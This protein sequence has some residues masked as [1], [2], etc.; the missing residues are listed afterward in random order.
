MSPRDDYPRIQSNYTERPSPARARSFLGT[1]PP[2]GPTTYPA[3]LPASQNKSRS[4]IRDDGE[5]QS[6]L[7]TLTEEN[8]A[9]ASQNP[10]LPSTSAAGDPRDTRRQQA[11]PGQG[12]LPPT[13]QVRVEQ[14]QPA[15]DGQIQPPAPTEQEVPPDQP[16]QQ[17][18]QQGQ[19]Q[20]V[21]PNPQAVAQP[22]DD[23]QPAKLDSPRRLGKLSRCGTA[24][25]P[26]VSTTTVRGMVVD[27]VAI[28]GRL[29]Q[30][31]KE[32]T[33]SAYAA[34]G[35]SFRRY[36]QRSGIDEGET[37]HGCRAGC[38]IALHM[39]GASQQEVMEHLG[40]F[41]KQ[42]AAHYM[43]V[44]RVTKPGAAGIKL[45]T[46]Q[47]SGCDAYLMACN[48]SNRKDLQDGTT[49]VLSFM[50]KL[51]KLDALVGWKAALLMAAT[52]VSEMDR[53]SSD[54]RPAVP[55]PIMKRRRANSVPA[56]GAERLSSYTNYGPFPATRQ[57]RTRI[58]LVPSLLRTRCVDQDGRQD[59]YNYDF[60]Y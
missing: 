17:T 2:P 46:L 56:A 45:K 16:A 9:M 47:S 36:L 24:K 28:D 48:H 7:G 49:A 26:V 15:A 38:A 50:K 27:H 41:T 25:V 33:D 40:W 18:Q 39:A 42:T 1:Y 44:G 21:V 60:S 37:L 32:H 59:L 30:V 20:A 3:P 12:V 29:E 52:N 43:K 57:A 19:D 8:L 5:L 51:G 54:L 13:A 34:L 4:A 31:M 35:N 22:R 58:L 14:L 23:S 55:S 11:Q 6:D 10:V 53:T